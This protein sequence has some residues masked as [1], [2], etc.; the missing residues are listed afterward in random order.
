M[1]TTIKDCGSAIRPA[2]LAVVVAAL[3]VPAG[4]ATLNDPFTFEAEIIGLDLGPITLDDG[5]TN[6]GT[7]D[8]PAFSAT[9]TAGDTGVATAGEDTPPDAFFGAAAA[10]FE[11]LDPLVTGNADLGLLGVDWIDDVTFD[12]V[13]DLNAV[14]STEGLVVLNA[15]DVNLTLVPT[16]NWTLSDIGDGF[17]I[18]TSVTPVIDENNPLLLPFAPDPSDISHTDDSI[19][20]SYDNT[21]GTGLSGQINGGDL[22]TRAR[23]QITTQEVPLPASFWFLLTGFGGLALLRRRRAGGAT[24]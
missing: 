13:F 15:V 14:V 3:S 18:I 2:S 12:L 7:V 9:V 5:I 20:I 24:A 21:V 19:S 8:I 1:N 23:F 6:L 10:D 22:E 11:V 4:A 17:T 16:V